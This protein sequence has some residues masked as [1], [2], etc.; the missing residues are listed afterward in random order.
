MK[1]LFKSFTDIDIKQDMF[2]QEIKNLEN[3]LVP[4]GFMGSMI[5]DASNKKE[6]ENF[7]GQLWEKM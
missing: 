5:E 6:Y 4:V 2:E 1:E 7:G 3:E